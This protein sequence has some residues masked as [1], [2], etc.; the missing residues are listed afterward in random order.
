MPTCLPIRD[1]CLFIDNSMLESLQTCPRAFYYNNILKRRLI[2]GKA[3][4][5]FGTACHAALEYRYKTIGNADPS[6]VE[7]FAQ[8]QVN[9]LQQHFTLNP[10]PEGDFRDLNWATEVFVKQYNRHY[11]QEPFSILLDK[12]GKPMV[13]LPFAVELYQ[14][15]NIHVIYCGRID[16]PVMWDGLVWV[17]DTKTTS[18]LGD[19]FWKHYRVS[20]QMLGYTWAFWKSTG[21]M[22]AGFFVNAVRV[23]R[24]PAKFGEEAKYGKR[25]QLLKCSNP[26]EWWSETFKRDQEYVDAK[27]LSDW[28]AN[29]IE[30]IEHLFYMAERHNAGNLDAFRAGKQWC[31]GKFGECQFYSVCDSLRES[32]ADLLDSSLYEPNTWSPLNNPNQIE[33]SRGSNYAI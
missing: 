7:G 2:G 19:N 32:H 8:Q 33:S 15:D 30:S 28:Q 27:K 29:T 16:L 23:S 11:G 25:G 13:E 18:M 9:L 6:T 21:T 10:P 26:E 12:T 4:L 24:M 5:N 14:H 17:G 20:P 3:A 31:C 1:N 22:P